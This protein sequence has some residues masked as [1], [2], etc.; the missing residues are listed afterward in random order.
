V[1]LVPDLL[2]RIRVLLAL[3]SLQRPLG[4]DVK[5]NIGS[6]NYPDQDEWNEDYLLIRKS[7]RPP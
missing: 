2:R 4:V 5:T 7:T 6:H 3:G 1:G